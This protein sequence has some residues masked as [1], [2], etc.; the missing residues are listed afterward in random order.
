MIA[1]SVAAFGIY[2]ALPVFW[3]LPT[4][5]LSGAAAAGGIAII[6]SLGNLSGYYGPSIV[7]FLKDRTGG[8]EAGLL[9][10]AAA[11]AVAFLIVLTLNHDRA[12]ERAPEAHPV[13]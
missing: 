5:F 12:L 1:L 6:N 10:L 9:A 11:G 2:G 4:A 13:E 7:G 8:F 3:T